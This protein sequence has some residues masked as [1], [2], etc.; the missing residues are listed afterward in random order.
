[1]N[2][3]ISI[4]IL[5]KKQNNFLIFSTLIAIL[6]LLL[7]IKI[8][9]S[10]HLLFLIWNLFLAIIP[11]SISSFIKIDFAITINNIKNLFYICFWLL[12]IP[13]TYYL[14]TDFI[15]LYHENNFQFIYDFILLSSFTIV[16]FYFGML[17]IYEIY[18]QFEFF[19]SKKIAFVFNLLI[20]YLCAF[21]IYLGRMLRFNSWDIISKPFTLFTTIF[22]SVFHI[23]TILFTFILGS[24]ITIIN[25][26]CFKYKSNF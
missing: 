6:L 8:T 18:C 11:Y 4:Y 17:S 14:I 23:E 2:N 13:N 3:F 19:Y 20:C 7:R 26:I 16:G 1:M 5:N 12:F 10:S 24:F 9:H 22:D 15:H 25:S 21:G